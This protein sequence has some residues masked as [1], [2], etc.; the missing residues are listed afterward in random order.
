[1]AT[2]AVLADLANP[3]TARGVEQFGVEE[4]RRRLAAI[5]PSVRERAAE[6]EANQIG[7]AHV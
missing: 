2:A 4:F 7:R 5:V 1:M 3:A 6:A